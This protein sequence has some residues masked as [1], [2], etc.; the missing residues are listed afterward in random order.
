M[1][2][3][4]VAWQVAFEEADGER[5]TRRQQGWQVAH[6]HSEGHRAQEP[7]PSLRPAWR[8]PG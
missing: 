2:A 7:A 4:R 3:G 1:K 6:E 8:T 5:G